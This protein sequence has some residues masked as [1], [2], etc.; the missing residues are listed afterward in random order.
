MDYSVNPY[1]GCEHG[2]VYC[3][4]RP[5]HEYWGYSPGLDFE[6]KILVK[7]NAPELLMK[8]LSSKSWHPAPIMFSGNTDCY[9]PVERELQ[10][11]RQMLNILLEYRNPVGI[12][13]KNSLILRDVDILREMH[14][15]NL[16][17]VVMS[18]TSLTESTRRIMEPRTSSCKN[19]LKAIEVLSQI[20]IPVTVNLA[21]II[22]G[23][24]DHEIPSILEA[25]SKA[26]A[27]KA[28]YIMVRLNGAIK[29]IFE[30][31][32]QE[33]FPDRAQK[34]MNQIASLHGGMHN[35]SRFGM[36]MRGEGKIAEQ[37]RSLFKIQHRK[38]FEPYESE[39]MNV[40]DF[41]KMTKGQFPLF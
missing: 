5:T 25:V 32:V 18:V 31:W 17:R 23:I 29:D 36:R 9:Q 22:P 4:A 3:Y 33:N 6:R 13:T 19:R 24:N 15:H 38:W 41:R 40:Q 8:Q 2:C 39:P 21:P 14:A 12:I 30:R 34:V 10:L 35:D 7:P 1:Q 27:V 26:G 11:T 20:G 28:N 16:V 37:I